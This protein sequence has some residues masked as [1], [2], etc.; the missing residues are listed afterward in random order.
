M[1]YLVVRNGRVELLSSGHRVMLGGPDLPSMSLEGNVFALCLNHLCEV[2]KRTHNLFH[3]KPVKAGICTKKQI[4]AWLAS[5]ALDSS[6]YE[7]DPCGKKVGWNHEA[8]ITIFVLAK[9]DAVG[10][11]EATLV[12]AGEAMRQRWKEE[13]ED[14][15]K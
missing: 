12:K 11:D 14:K 8:M 1:N 7:R 6:T 15:Q 2:H 3:R 9:L 4:A 13:K 5:G 10:F